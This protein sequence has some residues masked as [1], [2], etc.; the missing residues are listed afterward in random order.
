MP[1]LLGTVA[2]AHLHWR[3][4]PPTSRASH[5]GAP[6]ASN[7]STSSAGEACL[8]CS[9]PALGRLSCVCGEGLGTLWSKLCPNGLAYTH[10]ARKKPLLASSTPTLESAAAAMTHLTGA[11]PL[12][13]LWRAMRAL[14][15]RR[16]GSG[17]RASERDTTGTFMGALTRMQNEFGRNG[18]GAPEKF[19]LAVAR[20]MQEAY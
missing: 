10:L 20:N 4:R 6:L 5:T 1:S 16:G 7:T 3:I 17:Q 12:S 15:A 2:F 14:R 18:H 11:P 9:G 13:P 19:D 8:G